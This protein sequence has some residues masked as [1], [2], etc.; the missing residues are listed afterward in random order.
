MSDIQQYNLAKKFVF[1]KIAK[2]KNT[3]IKCIIKRY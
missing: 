2:I 3:K 1:V